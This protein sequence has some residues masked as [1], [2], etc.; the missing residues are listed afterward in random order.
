MIG[1]LVRL[2][3]RASTFALAAWALLALTAPSLAETP[4]LWPAED[5]RALQSILD[6]SLQSVTTAPAEQ[7]APS[8]PIGNEPSDPDKGAPA[9]PAAQAAV[10]PERLY[11][12]IVKVSARAVPN[13]RS[14]DTLGQ[15]REGTGVVIGSNGLIL[16]IGY[17]IAEADDV[18]IS[19]AKGRTFPAQVLAYDQA[20]GLGLVRSL[21]PFDATPIPLGDSASTSEHEPV[22]IASAEDTGAALAWIVSKRPFT[23]DWEYALDYALYTSPPTLGWS[24]AALI[25]RNGRL[26]GIGS[27]LVKEATDGETK[28]PG[29]LFVPIDLLKPVLADLVKEGHRRGPGRPWLGITAD[30]DGGHV[31]VTKVSPD[32]PA[33]LAGLE[34]GDVIVGVANDAVHSESELYHKLWSH[35]HAGDEVP[36]DIRQHGNVR[37]LRVRSID[38]LQYFR[39]KTTI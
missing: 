6:E 14:E 29:N 19:D 3:P 4:P 33:D 5:R 30:D 17:L 8:A 2:T 10:D 37:E 21:V 22:L 12:A 15:E 39:P 9:A 18:K 16:T 13:A 31:L 25:D 38:R 34:P 32:S 28:V 1:M 26:L 23:A 24:G 11:S 20:T 35:W 27:L 7:P 36:L